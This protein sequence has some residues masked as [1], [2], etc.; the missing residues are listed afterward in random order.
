MLFW[1]H[2]RLQFVGHVISDAEQGDTP[3]SHYID[4]ADM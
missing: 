4:L 2:D 3:L 1:F